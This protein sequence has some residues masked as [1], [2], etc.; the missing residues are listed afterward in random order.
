M[1]EAWDPLSGL[2]TPPLARQ[3]GA[4]VESQVDGQF[5]AVARDHVAVDRVLDGVRFGGDAA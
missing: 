4:G 2:M 3:N 5:L 1:I